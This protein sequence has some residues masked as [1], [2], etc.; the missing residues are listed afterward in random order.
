MTVILY[1]NHTTENDALV[2]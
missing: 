2:W 1:C